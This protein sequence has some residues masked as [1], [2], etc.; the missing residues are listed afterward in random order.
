MS[1]N[2]IYFDIAAV[3]IMLITI[4]TLIMRGMTRGATNRVYLVS[5]VLV[6]VT[7]IVSVAGEVCD[8]MCIAHQN[9]PFVGGIVIARN[10]ASLIYLAL[11][12]LTA[13]MYLILIATVTGT[14]HR[15][16]MSWLVRIALWVPM[17]AVCA[18]VLSNPIHHLVF[19]SISGMPSRGPLFWTLYVVATYYAA[20]GV[21]WLIRWRQLLSSMEFTVMLALYPLIYVSLIAQ[22]AYPVLNMEMFITSIAMMLLSAFVIRPE[23]RRDF[24]VNAASLQAYRDMTHRAFVTE[25]NRT[26]VYLEVMNLEQIRELVGKDTLQDILGGISNNLSKHL[27]RDDVLYYLHNGLFCIAPRSNDVDRT[28]KIAQEAH[29]EGRE[30]ALASR[31]NR[32]HPKMRTCI[33]RIPEDAPD[34]DTLKTFIRRFSYLVPDSC[35]T[36]YSL[37]SMKEDFDLEMALTDIVENAI[38]NRSF[39]VHYQPIWCAKDGKFHTA[40]ALIRLNDPKFGWIPPTLFVPEAEQN[41]LITEIGNIL[42]E[43]VCEFLG[44]F[45]Y[46]ACGLD[47]IEINLSADQCVRPG[48]A[49]ELLGVMDKFGVDSSR[50]N[51]EI[52]ETSSSFSQEAISENVRLLAGAGLVFSI[53]DYGT[54]YSNLKRTVELPFSIIKIDKSLADAYKDE[55]G[56]VLLADTIAM[57]KKVGKKVL[58]EG[59]ES[60]EQAESLIDM[61]IDYIQGYYY[62][63]PMPE[64][65]FVEFLKTQNAN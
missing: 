48:F 9:A 61:G 6:T 36:T 10:S 26:L 42:I 25:K 65:K 29:I 45:D 14:T 40:E 15:L 24:N 50:L 52:T 38:D 47:Y 41:G 56:R 7:A 60:P 12:S 30:R 8:L 16:D 43:K 46:E 13:P 49:Y 64:D 53:D 20:I 51:L 22:Y 5:M 37:L 21:A 39:E 3:V 11:R 32:M 62:A 35:V 31:D 44:T 18:F 54:G 33:V 17:L 59:I 23:T 58:A 28:V 2:L 55:K 57:M 63:K 34:N 1:P 27:L 19:V 4:T